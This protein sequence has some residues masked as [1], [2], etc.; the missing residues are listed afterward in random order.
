MEKVMNM[1]YAS[2]LTKLCEVNSSFDTG[3]LRICYPGE[4]RNKSFISKKDIKRCLP[5]IYNCPIVCNYNREDDSLGGHDI[6]LVKTAD[7]ELKLVNNTF[8]VGVIPE[9]AKV[10]FEEYEGEDGETHEYLYAEALLW[11]RQ[12]AYQKIK[13]DGITA[14][15]MEI[16]VKDGEMK[17]GIFYI[18]DFEFTAFTL[19]GVEPCFEDASLETF[20]KKDFKMEFS[21]M[22]QD[23]K[24]SFKQIS[25]SKEVDDTHPQNYSTEGGEGVLQEKMTL[26]AEYG[27]DIETLD[28]SIED[29]TIEELRQKFEEMS[30]EPNTEPDVQV[31]DNSDNDGTHVDGSFALNSNIVAEISRSLEEVKTEREWGTVCRYWFVDCDLDTNEVYCWDTDDWLLYGFKFVVD[32]DS[33]K[34]DFDS[35]KRKKYIVVDFDEGEEEQVSP[36]VS[37]FSEMAYIAHEGIE[38]Q[39]R[40]QTLSD[41]LDSQTQELN[42]LRDFKAGIEAD[43]ARNEREAVLNQFEDLAG[44]EAFE[45]LVSTCSEYTT[46]ELEEKCF[47]IRG[48]NN[49]TVKFSTENKIPKIKVDK[50]ETPTEPYGGLFIKYGFESNNE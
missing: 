35:K 3:I 21:A 22:M 28:F 41:T 4:N 40:F 48:R 17:D 25:T 14:Q 30:V 20:V 47:A 43:I 12:E 19:I 45:F 5:T 42:E 13:N 33:V 37:T 32:G 10:W 23:L 39:S 2:S 26:A 1:T 38:L 24:E 49:T 6:E 34:I 18:K 16:S 27:I 50:T 11:K 15:S 29:L 7:G 8:P 36:F 46:E 44:N 9:S 31:A